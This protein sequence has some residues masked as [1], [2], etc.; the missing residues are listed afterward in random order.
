[1]II[2]AVLL[3]I[4]SL[5]FFPRWQVNIAKKKLNVFSQSLDIKDKL[6][7]AKDFIAME[8]TYRLT[9][10]QII[11]GAVVLLGI[12]FS[13]KN[14][15]NSQ[16]S[17]T[18]A[19]EGQITDR[20]TKAINQLGD[21]NTDINIGGIYALQRISNESE[22]DYW[23]I[24]EVLTSYVRRKV[25]INLSSSSKGSVTDF[26]TGDKYNRPGYDIQAIMNVIS[27]RNP[28]I[29]NKRNQI[30]HLEATFL[31]GVV[32]D[33]AFLESAS[34]IQI[35]FA[36]SSFRDALLDSSSLA[37]SNLT[38]ANFENA[39][40][41]N[42]DLRFVNA[43]YS[44]LNNIHL[45]NANLSSADLRAT[46]FKKIYV[47]GAKF[48]NTRLEGLDLRNFIGLSSS[49]LSEAITDEYTTLPKGIEGKK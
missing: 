32:L 2:L 42:A 3:L 36:F 6:A 44:N 10:S 14:L 24:M 19:Q 35:D 49:Q 29:E 22:K 46:N 45:E 38:H 34:L 26:G 47:A 13:L 8:N 25:P 30:I 18:L 15:E 7:L 23:P 43:S 21:E 4:C 33:H 17:L 39:S 28:K 20:F 48:T 27:D 41:R 40:L 1:M 9:I 16:K 31:Q 12:Y 37:Y 5:I 11:A